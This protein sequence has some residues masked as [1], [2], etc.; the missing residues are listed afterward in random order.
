[1]IKKV[2]KRNEENCNKFKLKLKKDKKNLKDNKI[3]INYKNKV[4]K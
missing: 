4:I 1:M 2:S 3:A